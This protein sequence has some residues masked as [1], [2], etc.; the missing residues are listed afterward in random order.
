MKIGPVTV[1]TVKRT[2]IER[3]DPA[4]RP[5]AFGVIWSL[6]FLLVPAVHKLKKK[7]NNNPYKL[8]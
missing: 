5:L 3:E 1:K 8:F 7:A 6:E 2:E 4:R